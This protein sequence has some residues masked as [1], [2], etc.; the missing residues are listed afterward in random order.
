MNTSVNIPFLFPFERKKGTAIKAWSEDL[1][2]LMLFC[3]FPGHNNHPTH[4]PSALISSPASVVKQ[5]QTAQGEHRHHPG[6][7]CSVPGLCSRTM[8]K[9]SNTSGFICFIKRLGC[10]LQGERPGTSFSSNTLGRAETG[11]NTHRGLSV[12]TNGS[13]SPERRK[14]GR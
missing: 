7:L 4:F 1:G 6:S 2:P 12:S 14:E 8:T 5:K 11:H 3:V 13:T 10:S 9:A